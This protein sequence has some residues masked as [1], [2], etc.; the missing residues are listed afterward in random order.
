MF[1]NQDVRLDK[2]TLQCTRLKEGKN[3]KWNWE[4]G[5]RAVILNHERFCHK[6][7]GEKM[8]D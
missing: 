1:V 4:L 5:L 2:L 7:L 8:L 3:S 6:L